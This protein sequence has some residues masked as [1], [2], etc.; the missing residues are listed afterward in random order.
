MVLNPILPFCSLNT[1]SSKLMPQSIVG[2]DIA[3]LKFD[4]AHLCEGK[5]RHKKLDNNP[6][7]FADFIAWLATFG[8]TPPWVC[9]EATGA[10]SIPLW[11]S[12]WSD[13]AIRSVS[14]IPPRF[15]PSPRAN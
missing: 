7:G 1:C 10:Y 6:A 9:M 11:P 12:F 8:D 14:S 15:M 5:Y 4:A 2:V 3:K 13:G